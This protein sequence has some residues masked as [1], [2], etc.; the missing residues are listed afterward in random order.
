MFHH[1]L[2]AFGIILKTHGIQGE[3]IVS[4]IG[5][6]PAKFVLPE[7]IFIVINGIP[8][9]FFTESYEVISDN[10]LR[11]KFDNIS[12]RELAMRF[13]NCTIMADRKF[14]SKY[15]PRQRVLNL[16]SFTV[17]N[18]ENRKVGRITEF[19][20]IPGNPVVTVDTGNGF[21]MLPVS[22]DLIIDIYEKGKKIVLKIPEG[23]L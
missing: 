15:F 2:S 1:K 19:S 14:V 18:Q 17:F 8:V 4:V 21:V 3:F 10:S 22:K 6:I 13:Y 20:D 12:S 11:I 5:E 7:S 16:V 23:L 9:P